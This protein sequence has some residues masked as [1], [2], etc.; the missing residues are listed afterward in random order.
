[1]KT[2]VLGL[3]VVAGIMSSCS[4]KAKEET[5][6][7]GLNPKK[8][9]AEID[10]K[11]AGLYTLKNSAGMEVCITNFGGRIVSVLVPDKHGNRKDVVLGF[12][13]L[14]DYRNIPSDF[15]A[16][17][18]RYANRIAQGRIEIDGETIQLPQNNY[19]HC[20]HGGPEGWQY[21][22]YEANQIDGTTLELTRFSPDGDQNFPG[23]VR[24]KVRFHLTDDNAID[25]QYEA[26]TDKKTVINMTNHSYFNLSGNP[27]V[28]ATD[29][30]LYVNADGYTPVDSTFMTTG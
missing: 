14:A 20:L 22:M 16:S 29:H 23:N 6:L 9:Q 24:A 26:V 8:F 5:T 18:G 13:S 2:F 7:S 17:I 3:V 11:Q 28:A 12:D 1:M 21:Q 19:G 10:G 4:P 25:I 30:L 15:G 27:A